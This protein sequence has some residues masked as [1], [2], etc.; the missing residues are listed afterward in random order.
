MLTSADDGWLDAAA[1]QLLDDRGEFDDFRAGP[2]DHGEGHPS[3]SPFAPYS[4]T[5]ETMQTTR[6]IR[7]FI[8]SRFG[9]RW[10]WYK[11]WWH[12][13]TGSG[14]VVYLWPWERS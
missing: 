6:K 8:A 12:Y 10:P 2:V 7:W 4:A 5:F 11:R 9:E 13:L 3:I 14:R 1:P